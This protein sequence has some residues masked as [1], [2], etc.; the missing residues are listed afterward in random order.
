MQNFNKNDYTVGNKVYLLYIGGY[1]TEKKEPEQVIY[2]AVVEKVG[3]KYITVL[4]GTRNI[5]FEYDKETESIWQKYDYGRDYEI[6][7]TRG[8]ALEALNKKRLEK[9]ICNLASRM[10]CSHFDEN[11]IEQ[12]ELLKAIMVRTLAKSATEKLPEVLMRL[13]PSREKDDL[14]RKIW[15]EHVMEDIKSFAANKGIGLSNEKVKETAEAYVNGR[16]DCNL[17]YWENLQNVIDEI[18]ETE[19][20]PECYTLHKCLTK[21]LQTEVS[22][23][24]RCSAIDIDF[25]T[26]DGKEDEV[27][28]NVTKNI[29]TR[30]GKEELE[31][32]F[33]SL[34]K[35]L[36]TKSNRI[37]SCTVVAS[38]YTQ[39]EL[40]EMGY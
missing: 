3:R 12:L 15:A 32:L 39:E 28:L 21:H 24:K 34:T 38:A 13:L 11:S 30:A 19:K 20:E 22:E 35:E 4:K 31:E 29:L 36:N 17:S 2:E 7:P 27:Q 33:A 14:Y 10:I 9:D 5:R 26:N 25:L 18:P 40:E 1:G 37:L 6:Y 8:K 16:Y 23:I